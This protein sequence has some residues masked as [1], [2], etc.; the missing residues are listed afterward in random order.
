M[1][2]SAGNSPAISIRGGEPWLMGYCCILFPHDTA[3][4]TALDF[5]NFSGFNDTMYEVPVSAL[6][7]SPT[8]SV[9][10]LL[11]N[12]KVPKCVY[13]TCLLGRQKCLR[14]FRKKKYG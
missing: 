3:A 13:P 8:I 1:R 5:R 12:S 10:I 11:A 14:N 9:R 6:G 4:V 2:D 7:G